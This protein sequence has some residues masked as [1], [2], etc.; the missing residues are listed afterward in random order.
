[1][2]VESVAQLGSLQT[3]IMLASSEEHAI[4]ILKRSYYQK[5]DHIVI[6]DVMFTSTSMASILTHCSFK[7]IVIIRCMCNTCYLFLTTNC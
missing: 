2:L 1:M 4:F 3:S 7:C 6:D 5:N